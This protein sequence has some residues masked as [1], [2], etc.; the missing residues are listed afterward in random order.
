MICLANGMWY[1]WSHASSDPRTPEDLSAFSVSVM[2][3]SLGLPVGDERPHGAEL[4]I[5]MMPC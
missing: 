2:G 1:K 3:T 5:L 4:V